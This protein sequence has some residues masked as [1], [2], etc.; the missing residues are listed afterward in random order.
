MF[1]PACK[2]ESSNSA[3]CEWCFNP[4]SGATATPPVQ[5]PS[6]L[7]PP[8]P[9]QPLQPAATP[10]YLNPA[11]PIQPMQPMQPSH[12]VQPLAAKPVAAGPRPLDLTQPIPPCLDLTQPV[13]HGGNV[14]MSLTGEIVEVAPPSTNPMPGTFSPPQAAYVQPGRP[15]M[16]AASAVVRDLPPGAIR[17]EMLAGLQHSEVTLAEKWEKCLAMMLPTLLLAVV[18]V[19]FFPNAYLGIEIGALFLS[20]LYMGA[21]G[22]IGTYDEAFAECMGVLI[23]SYFFGPI[24]GLGGCLL[25]G[26]IRQELNAPVCGLLAV[27]IIA[28]FMMLVSA[29]MVQGIPLFSAE[30]DLA[31][32]LPHLNLF[33]AAGFISFFIIC[34]SF[35][36]W[37]MSSFFRP[38]NE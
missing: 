8:H 2:R 33:S 34:A 3:S 17:P 27:H 21:T 24:V 13:S 35:A 31:M 37:M 9:V 6:Y 11:P 28:R 20:A 22:A 14:R 15:P 12:P 7:N 18:G 23:I 25:L 26:L 29:G 36:G 32:L 10:S 5:T 38:V 16:P 1:C 19:H 30:W 4:L